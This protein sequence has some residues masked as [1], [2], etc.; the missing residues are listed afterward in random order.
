MGAS[1]AG[2][3]GLNSDGVR[4]VSNAAF[5]DAVDDVAGEQRDASAPI[6][7]GFLSNITKEKGIVEF[8][9]VLSRLK[10][11]GVQ[12]RAVIAGPLATETRPMFEDLLGAASDVEYVGPVYG[13]QKE[14]FYHQLDIFLFPTKYRNEAEPLVVYEALRC[15]VHV[16]A[17]DRGAIAELLGNGAGMVFAEDAIVDSAATQIAMFSADRAALSGA[18]QL[19]LRQAQRV[20]ASGRAALENLLCTMQR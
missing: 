10:R 20:R 18:Q 1:L 16:M 2:L 13:E 14:R 4:V 15:A 11:R 17:C 6:C 3:Y 7:I 19:S 8:F 12:Y 9:E 5:Y